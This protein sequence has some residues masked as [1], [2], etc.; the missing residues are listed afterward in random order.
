M[1]LT[2]EQ[3]ELLLLIFKSITVPGEHIE[4]FMELKTSIKDAKIE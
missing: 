1:T 2:K 3:Q 4:K